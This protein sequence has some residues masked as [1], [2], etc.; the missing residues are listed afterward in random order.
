MRCPKCKAA[1]SRNLLYC[2]RCEAADEDTS[3]IS[4]ARVLVLIIFKAISPFLILW[5][6]IA[7]AVTQI[8]D[9]GERNVWL[10]LVLI[11]GFIFYCVYILVL[12]LICDYPEI[13]CQK[14]NTA[15]SKPIFQ[16]A[17]CRELFLHTNESQR[18]VMLIVSVIIYTFGYTL[19]FTT[20]DIEPIFSAPLF[21]IIF[22]LPAI[23][24]FQQF[25]QRTRKLVEEF[26][27][28]R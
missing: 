14:C 3:E 2:P 11:L 28:Q 20:Q 17:H 27:S 26:R 6:I 15:I 1:N 13:E 21:S 18:I 7:L 25:R 9:Y 5:L 12:Y 4:N 23:P 24:V 16:C 10:G 19:M 8:L 22:A